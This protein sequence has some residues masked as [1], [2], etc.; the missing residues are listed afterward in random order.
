M[1]RSRLECFGTI[2]KQF[3][4]LTYDDLGKAKTWRE[5]TRRFW[6]SLQQRQRRAGIS[7][8]IRYFGC[9]DFGGRYGR[10]HIHY[11][12]WDAIIECPECPSYRKGFPRPPFYFDLWPHGHVDVGQFNTATVNYV[13]GYIT[14]FDKTGNLRSETRLPAIGYSGLKA[15]AERVARR[16]SPITSP[17]LSIEIDG[18]RFPC[19]RWTKKTF[20]KVFKAA[21]GEV[22][23]VPSNPRDRDWANEVI[24]QARD[25]A[26]PEHVNLYEEVK[27]RRYIDGA[28]QKRAAQAAVEA[29]ATADYLSREAEKERAAS[30]NRSAA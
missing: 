25:K 8:P 16:P 18:R 27:I 14:D 19:D 21:G 13:T 12:V 26:L 9:L 1:L 11:L 4:T 15:L 30:L 23:P 10:P 24:R 5:D 3:W 22:R 7:R 2:T 6:M 20:L 29:A 17:P 28:E